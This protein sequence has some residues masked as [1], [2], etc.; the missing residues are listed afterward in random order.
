MDVP[1]DRYGWGKIIPAVIINGNQGGSGIKGG[2]KFECKQFRGGAKFECNPPG[3]TCGE[4]AVS[5]SK[6][7]ETSRNSRGL[8]RWEAP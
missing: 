8:Y 4:L 5:Y 1:L 2:Q 3:I 7:A 6:L